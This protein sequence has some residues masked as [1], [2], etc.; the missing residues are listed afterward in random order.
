MAQKIIKF[1]VD[2]GADP[3]FNPGNLC[4]HYALTVSLILKN[5]VQSLCKDC[6]VP[7]FSRHPGEYA[8][9]DFCT[10]NPSHLLRN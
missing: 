9:R 10:S 2:A 4:V 3:D 7:N 6:P 1:L 8:Q 5:V